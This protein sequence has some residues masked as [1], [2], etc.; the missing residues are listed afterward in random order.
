[1]QQAVAGIKQ[2]FYEDA[3]GSCISNLRHVTC[4]VPSRQELRASHHPLRRRQL[5]VD[6]NASEAPTS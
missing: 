1:V 3:A 5:A 2:N 4:N 6:L